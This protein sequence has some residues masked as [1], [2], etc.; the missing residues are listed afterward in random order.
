MDDLSE[1]QPVEHVESRQSDTVGDYEDNEIGDRLD[2][3]DG[4]ENADIFDKIVNN[5]ARGNTNVEIEPT[6]SDQKELTIVEDFI[7]RGCGCKLLKGSPCCEQFSNE[8]I[9]SVQSQCL[10]LSRDELDLVILGQIMAISNFSSANAPAIGYPSK[11]RVNPHSK[12]SHGSQPICR[13]MFQFLHAIGNLRLNSLIANFRHHGLTPRI[14]GNTKK[15]PHNALSLSSIEHFVKFLLNY[16]DQ[17]AILLPGRIPGY[18][19]MDIKL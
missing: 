7:K 18:H 4:L 1:I 12:Y 5:V 9:M 14:H 13:Q 10:S 15:R 11:H 16:S 3:D 2:E 6:L 19:K 17:N 8:Y